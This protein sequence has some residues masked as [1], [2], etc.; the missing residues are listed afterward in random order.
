M[1]EHADAATQGDL[2]FYEW[3][4]PA[5]ALA[6]EPLCIQLHNGGLG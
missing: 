4:T 1:N 5:E 6:P 2:L 3:K